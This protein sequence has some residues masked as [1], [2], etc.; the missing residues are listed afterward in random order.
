MPNYTEVSQE[1]TNPLAPFIGFV[2]LLLVSG[3]SYLAAP[4]VIGWLVTANWTVAGTQLLPFSFPGNWSYLAIR[5]SVA[6]GLFLVLFVLAMIVLM[7]VMGSARGETDV[8]YDDLR[9][10]KERKKKRRR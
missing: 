1:R 5:L 6:A 9:K 4:A 8:S 7:I 10:E 3:F 2:V